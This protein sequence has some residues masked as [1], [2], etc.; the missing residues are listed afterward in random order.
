MS[1]WASEELFTHRLFL[2]LYGAH[3]VEKSGPISFATYILVIEY[4]HVIS[5]EG[6]NRG[7]SCSRLIS[8]TVHT[9]PELVIGIDGRGEHAEAIATWLHPI[10]YAVVGVFPALWTS[11]GCDIDV[12]KSF[13]LPI[14]AHIAS[15]TEF[16]IGVS[17]IL[18]ASFR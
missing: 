6:L 1:F 10:E 13:L 5:G 3:R 2:S 17:N 4:V 11:S 12:S 16:E 7:A 8:I 15:P 18:N 14:T 9:I